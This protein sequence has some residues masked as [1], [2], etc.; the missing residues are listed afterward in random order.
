MPKIKEI[1]KRMGKIVPIQLIE[2]GDS[3]T[4]L[5]TLGTRNFRHLHSGFTLMEILIAIVIFATLLTTIYASYTGTFRVINDTES[6]AEIY[7]TARITMERMIEDL[8]SVYVQKGSPQ[9][10][11]EGSKEPPFQF[12]GEVREIMGRRADTLRFIS[13]AHIDFSGQDPGHGAAQIGYYVKESED[14]EGFVLYRSDNPLFK[15]TNPLYEEPG[16]LVLCEG[17]ISVAFTYYGEGGR[18]S[19]SWDSA[20]KG[21]EN[22]IPKEVSITLEFENTLNPELPIRFMTSVALPMEQAYL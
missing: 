12:L 20:S 9:A 4:T 16:G 15:E 1:Y 10:G 13:S 7:R 17:L 6:Q 22:K 2:Q 8:E 3:F 5:G 21:L 18:T 11:S 19:D 14:Q